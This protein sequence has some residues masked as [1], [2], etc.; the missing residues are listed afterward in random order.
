MERGRERRNESEKE[1]KGSGPLFQYV[2]QPEENGRLPPGA[3][4]TDDVMHLQR[5]KLL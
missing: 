4:A 5:V 1:R 2:L 3:V